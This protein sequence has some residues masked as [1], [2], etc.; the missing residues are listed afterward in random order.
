MN[1]GKKMPPDILAKLLLRDQCDRIHTAFGKN[2]QVDEDYQL[3][4]DEIERL[5]FMLR[6]ELDEDY[7]A[8]A[9][10]IDRDF[11]GKA[12]DAQGFDWITYYSAK[13]RALQ[14]L[15][16]RLHLKPTHQELNPWMVAP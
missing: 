6:Y 5:Q 14:E 10:K 1:R 7:L 4:K 3:I 11:E 13:W 8:F 9:D 2:P 12:K 15:I 16:R